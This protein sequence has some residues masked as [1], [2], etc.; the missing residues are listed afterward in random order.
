M[1]NGKAPGAGDFVN[2]SWA[3]LD[4]WGAQDVGSVCSGVEAPAHHGGCPRGHHVC[5]AARPLLQHFAVLLCVPDAAQVPSCAKGTDKS[6][7]CL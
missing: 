1:A 6:W 3:A 7:S 5:A 4:H 2:L